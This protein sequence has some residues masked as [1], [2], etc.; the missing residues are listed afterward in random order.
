M[1]AYACTVVC[2]ENWIRDCLPQDYTNYVKNGC[3]GENNIEYAG[4]WGYDVQYLATIFAN[5]EMKALRAVFDSGF[6]SMFW[7][8]LCVLS[9]LTQVC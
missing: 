7:F 2:L 3:D 9:C 1:D 8:C 6:F 5:D 4:E